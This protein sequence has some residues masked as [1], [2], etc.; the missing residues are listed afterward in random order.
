MVLC[1]QLIYAHSADCADGKE[2]AVSRGFLCGSAYEGRPGFNLERWAFWKQ[3]FRQVQSM[4]KSK[5]A[6]GFEEARFYSRKAFAA[7]LAVESHNEQMAMP[8]ELLP[9]HSGT[10]AD[11][12]ESSDGITVANDAANGSGKDNDIMTKTDEGDRKDDEMGDGVS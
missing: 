12:V 3:R 10:D 6:S 7:M 1:C 8:A 9:L 4:R 5:K 2:G 11:V